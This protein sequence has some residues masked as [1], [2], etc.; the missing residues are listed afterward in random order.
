MLTR[1]M[2]DVRQV[3]GEFMHITS[4]AKTVNHHSTV[5]SRQ[6]ARH[7]RAYARSHVVAIMVSAGFG[8]CRKSSR[9]LNLDSDH[10][11]DGSSCK[12]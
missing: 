8:C 10:R 2:M 3:S 1:M 4:S 5:P 7:S 6:R 11:S 9:N 12:T